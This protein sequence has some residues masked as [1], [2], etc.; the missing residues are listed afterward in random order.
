MPAS[1]IFRRAWRNASLFLE[2]L[3][4]EDAPAAVAAS[5]SEGGTG[6]G[7]VAASSPGGGGGVGLISMPVNAVL[8]TDQFQPLI[9]SVQKKRLTDAPTGAQAAAALV[10]HAAA[11]GLVDD[12]EHH[13]RPRP[14]WRSGPWGLLAQATSMG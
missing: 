13:G 2:M 12:G 11:H 5:P 8:A 10:R 1:S 9:H 4:V 7:P 6:V 14:R 3:V